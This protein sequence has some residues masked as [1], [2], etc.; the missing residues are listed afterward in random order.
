MRVTQQDIAKIAKVSQATVSRV[1]AGDEKVEG[2]IRERVQEAMRAHNYTP[3]VRAR[4]LRSKC[5]QLIG[6]VINRPD[7]GLTNDPFFAALIAE[8]IDVLSDTPFHLC[9]DMVNSQESQIAAYEDL[10]RTR[11]VDGVILVESEATDDRI[12]RLQDE[13]F[14]FVLI[15]NPLASRDIISIDND[16]VL[17][18]EIA[19]RHLIDMGY[20]RVGIIGAR[21]GITVS[22]DR[23][24]GYCRAVDYHQSQSLVWHAGFGSEAA[25]LRALDALQRPDR[26]DALLVLDDFMAMGVLMAARELGLRVPEDLGL[27]SF[28][29]SPLCEL[30]EGGLT[31]V[32]LG[33]PQMIRKACDMLLQTIDG[34]GAE[35]PRRTIIPSELRVRGSSRRI[36]G[37]GA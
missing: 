2:A 6:L 12:A 26:P 5:T 33:I 7:G 1:L 11:R 31:S 8:I 22:E 20:E 3:D 32:N 16:N 27:L 25:R 15:G 18:A 30:V 9:V 21:K 35:L 4:S 29:D 14:P 10:L 13:G 28:N 17:A 37:S 19:A 36:G 23:I 24:A 34:N